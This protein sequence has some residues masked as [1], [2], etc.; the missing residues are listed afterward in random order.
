MKRL[1]KL[2]LKAVWRWTAP[3]RRPV[4]ARYETVL[5]RCVARQP[6][7]VCQVTAETNLLMDNLVRELVR[8]QKQ[9]DLLQSAVEAFAPPTTGL[10]VVGGLDGDDD[11]AHAAAG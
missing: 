6:P 3:L 9:V 2:P 7:H 10:A 1:L 5:V 4:M 11:E 8:L